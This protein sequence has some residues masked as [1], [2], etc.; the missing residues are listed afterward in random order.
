MGVAL[1][2]RQEL[3]P[4]QPRTPFWSSG[5]LA[6]RGTAV[7]ASHAKP[8]EAFLVALAVPQLDAWQRIT[9]YIQA[10]RGTDDDVTVSGLCSPEEDDDDTEQI[11]ELTLLAAIPEYPRPALSIECNELAKQRC[12]DLT[13]DQRSAIDNY[14]V[15]ATIAPVVAIKQ[16]ESIAPI[17]P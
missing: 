8:F 2:P 1:G 16:N 3:L 9:D 4:D 6:Q 5:A 11:N 12:E 17:A 7:L 10:M 13:D 14:V 15:P